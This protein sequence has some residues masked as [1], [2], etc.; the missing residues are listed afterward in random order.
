MLDNIP[1]KKN[2]CLSQ[3]ILPFSINKNHIKNIIPS[4]IE[5]KTR[6]TTI[7]IIIKIELLNKYPIKIKMPAIIPIKI[8]PIIS[9]RNNLLEID[10]VFINSTV[11]R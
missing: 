1:K 3:M 5:S 9:I 10:I 11:N 7:P 6:P 2:N 8:T 4:N